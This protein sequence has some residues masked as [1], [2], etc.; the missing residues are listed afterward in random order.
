VRR[1]GFATTADELEAGL[2]AIAA[3]VRGPADDVIA[4]LSI[5]GPTLRLTRARVAEL[6]PILVQ[7]A[8]ALDERLGNKHRPG[9]R[10]A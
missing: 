8:H 3:P 2:S 1:D 6:A 7:E 9:E 10:A 4:A 5:S